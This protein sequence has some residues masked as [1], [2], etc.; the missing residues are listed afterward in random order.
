M[1]ARTRFGSTIALAAALLARCGGDGVEAT[2]DAADVGGVLL[3]D[4]APVAGVVALTDFTRS[5]GFFSAPVPSEDLRHDGG[6]DVSGWPNPDDNDLVAQLRDVVTTD[7]GGFPVSST[8]Y[9]PFDGD[10]DPTALPSLADS[11][12]PE[13]G[14]FLAD[15]D[16]ASDQR[17]RRVP[18]EVSFLYDAGPYGAPR[19]LAVLPLQGAPLRPDTL[20]AAVVLRGVGDATGAPL[21]RSA[22]LADLLAGR[23]VAGLDLAAR[24]AYDAALASL[25][26]DGVDLAEVAGLAVFRTHDATLELS[27][28]IAAARTE[29]P[30]APGGFGLNEVFDDYCVYE[31]TVTVP[32]FQHG[33]PPFLGGPEAGGDWRRDASGAPTLTGRETARVVV[34]VPRSAPPAAGFPT[35]VFVRTGGGGDRPLVDRGRHAEVHGEAEPGSGPAREL[36]AVGFAGVSVDGP[37]GGLRNTTGA[38]EQFLVFNVTNARALRDNVRQSA[39]ELALLPDALAAL[40]LDTSACPGAPPVTRFDTGTLALMGHSMGATIAPLTVAAEPRYGA[41]ILSGEGG[42]YIQQIPYKREPIDVAPVA[43]GLL[44]YAARPLLPSDPALCLLQWAAE[45]SDPQIYAPRVREGGTHVLMLQGIVDHYNLPPMANAVS[46]PLGLDLG[47][48]SLDAAEPSLAA[49][50]PLAELLPLIG[51][52]QRALPID[53]GAGST[54]VVVQ[55][56][57]DGIEDGHEVVFQ[58]AAPKR[59]YRCFL[60]DFAAGRAPRVVDGAADPDGPCPP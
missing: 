19:L 22:G 20:H 18:V 2:A 55:F 5:D 38:D 46:L 50:R 39:L 33:D 60:A 59:T 35:L 15:V 16:P 53:D 47:G 42:S 21:G 56:P 52:R 51:G 12:E 8:I 31:G 40:A 44:G 48:P 57:E 37:L 3:P 26:E 54:R 36:A 32:T 28:Y 34:T 17:G 49:F 11:V 13:A 24:E 9:L 4:A 1:L 6:V 41:L 14:V 27:A 43:R 45:A 10:L 25:A 23:E 58:T 29:E 30:L 7:A